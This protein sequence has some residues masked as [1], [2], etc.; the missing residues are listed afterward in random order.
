MGDFGLCW[1]VLSSGPFLQFFGLPDCIVLV[2]MNKLLH[3]DNNGGQVG[4]SR[5]DKK[6]K[7][8]PL[9][10]SKGS[11]FNRRPGIGLWWISGG[12]G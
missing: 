9:R 1:R 2:K 5:L 3:P 8:G 12:G 7:S 10:F 4:C 6:S 11:L